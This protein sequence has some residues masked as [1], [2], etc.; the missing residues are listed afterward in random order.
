MLYNPHKKIT[1][2]FLGLSFLIFALTFVF[3]ITRQ[4]KM[5]ILV[6]PRPERSLFEKV[7][8]LPRDFNGQIINIKADHQQR[9]SAKASVEVESVAKGEVE[10]FNNSN[11]NLNLIKT[12]RFLS[13]TNLLFRL[14][15]K[16]FVPAKGKSTAKVYADKVGAEYE[17][18]PTRFT[19]PGLS[20][21]THSQVYAVSKEKMKGGVEKIGKITEQDI[22][23]AK[24]TFEKSLQDKANKLLE[25][26]VKEKNISLVE[27]KLLRVKEDL[28]T[29]TDAKPGEAMG[30]FTFKGSL[31]VIVISYNENDLLNL[32]T[33]Y[34]N[35]SL[36]ADQKLKTVETN[37]LKVELKK[38]SDD[39]QSADLNISLKIVTL[40]KDNSSI[41]DLEK[42]QKIQPAE[43]KNFLE[44]YKE[45]ESVKIKF[46]PF[47]KTKTPDQK[48]SI[49]IK[50][51]ESK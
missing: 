40:I 47:W 12:T 26:K 21:P 48:E 9:F 28:K 51:Y 50:I 24:I 49:E 41:F 16:V 27:W 25:E 34:A 11:Q 33:K 35:E 32:I 1:F 6:E 39:N 5:I 14:E 44:Q 37:T 15:E 18:E 20:E 4:A 13:P 29:E 2:F 31:T 8:R 38:I 7:I 46:N 23:E 45:I 22:N 42:L 36:A 30:E 43:I 17:I 3:F 10:I 19:L